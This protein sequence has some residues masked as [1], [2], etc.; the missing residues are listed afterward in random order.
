MSCQ[1]DNPLVTIII[2]VYNRENTISRAIN[3]VLG[4]T[5]K[6]I[7]IIVVDDCSTDTTVD[8]I[9]EFKDERIRLICLPFNRGANFARN[10][11]IE[12]ANGEFIA[13]QDSDDEWM[14][15]KLDRQINYMLTE[16]L[17]ASFSPYVLFDEGVS[18]IIPFNY[19]NIDLYRTKIKEELRKRN[20][21]GTPTLI[22]KKN[23]FC[24]I[25]MFDET[26]PRFQDYEFV[27]RLVK[28][29]RLGYISEPL[30]RAYRMQES[31]S[32]NKKVL[33]DAYKI[34]LKKHIDF[35][36]LKCVINNI[37]DNTDIF[38]GGEVNWNKFDELIEYIGIK[39]SYE[40]IKKIYKMELEYIYKKYFVIKESFVNWYDLFCESIKTGEFAIYGAGLYGHKAYYDLKKK[41]RIPQFFLVTKKEKK[42][43]ID[44]IEVVELSEDIDKNIPI[45]IAVSCEKQYELMKNLQIRGIDRFCLYPFC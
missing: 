30:V 22:V 6:N 17:D 36:D 23:I 12:Q 21:V 34:L 11:G 5:Y 9:K 32:V 20:V 28:K 1:S 25:G 24:Q 27:I 26:M 29:F 38:G 35:M 43:E 42:Q 31:I 19:Q 2:P 13:F 37:F 44:G 3:S 45:I 4:Q 18:Q 41:N 14:V 16:R 7:E 10:R 15:N 33:L 39:E 40:D 8:K